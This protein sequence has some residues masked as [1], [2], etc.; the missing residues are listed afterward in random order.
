MMNICEREQI[1]YLPYYLL[2]LFSL[3]NGKKKET[4]RIY[5]ND[6]KQEKGHQSYKI[7]FKE[8]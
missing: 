7:V 5:R 4:L 6:L 1:K 2:K 8:K 3:V